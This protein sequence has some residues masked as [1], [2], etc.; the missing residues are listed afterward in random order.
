[1]RVVILN[2][3]TLIT[4]FR[5]QKTSLF[6]VKSDI[7]LSKI[8]ICANKDKYE[9]TLMEH[10]NRGVLYFICVSILTIYS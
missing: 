2:I 7:K 3:S 6:M 4:I 8:I 9:R 1:M 10:Y 5:F